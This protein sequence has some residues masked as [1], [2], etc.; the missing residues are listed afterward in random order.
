LGYL[1]EA[2][3]NKPVIN[4]IKDLNSEKFAD[5]VENIT[6]HQT[7]SMSS[8]I[9]ISADKLKLIMA[10]AKTKGSN[11]TQE[12]LQHTEVISLESQTFKY[13]GLD[14]RITMQVLENVV[15]GSAKDFIKNEILAKMGI[16]VYDWKTDLNGL[17]IADNGASLTSRDMLKLGMLVINKGKWNGEQLISEN[18]LN[19][20]TK[21]ITE[22]TEDWIPS[23]FSYGYFW[24]QTDMN[25]DNKNYAAKIS[26]GGGGQYILTIEELNLVMVITG[27]DFEDTILT[28]ISKRVLS[29]FTK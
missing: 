17:P 2:D 3:L 10:S 24:Y 23:N 13:Q 9:R 19:N 26:W 14:T 16:T 18:F 4:F 8:G 1:T 11:L 12:L 22:P 21:K 20:A 29:G 27:H 15:P 28:P 5:G 25:V 7:M 6:L